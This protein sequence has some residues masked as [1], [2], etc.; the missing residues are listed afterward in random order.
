MK[1]KLFDADDWAKLEAGQDGIELIKLI[2][3]LI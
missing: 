1:A 3:Q 2:D